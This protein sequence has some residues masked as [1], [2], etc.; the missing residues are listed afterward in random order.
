M[1][2]GEQTRAHAGLPAYGSE[3]RGGRAFSVCAGDLNGRKTVL[4]V[5]ERR[6]EG[7]SVPEA[8]FYCERL[9]PETEKIGKRVGEP[10]VSSSGIRNLELET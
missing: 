2:R 6:E 3:H 4:G 8:E 9:M 7:L 10:H 5:A 1:R